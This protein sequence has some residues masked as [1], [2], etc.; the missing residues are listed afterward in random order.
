MKYKAQINSYNPYV[1]DVFWPFCSEYRQLVLEAVLGWTKPAKNGHE[2]AS[3]TLFH[4]CPEKLGW[5][6]TVSIE[7]YII[8][9]IIKES[10]TEN[11]ILSLQDPKR[12]TRSFAFPCNNVFI[13]GTDYSRV[14][15]A[16][17]TLGA[18][19]KSLKNN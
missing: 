15:H 12:K 6:K 10:N 19:N 2:L 4:T 9:K 13:T 18:E 7:N 17:P 11:G 8:D 5:D 1:L 14:I 3:H 16:E